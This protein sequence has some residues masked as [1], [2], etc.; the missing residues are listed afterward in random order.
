[1]SQYIVHSR[2]YICEPHLCACRFD[3]DLSNFFEYIPLSD[4][5]EVE[6]YKGILLCLTKEKVNT[7]AMV[8]TILSQQL[9][10][11]GELYNSDHYLR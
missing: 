4:P 8:I 6:R 2:E 5:S 7:H 1:M 10:E 3:G 11:C 9:H